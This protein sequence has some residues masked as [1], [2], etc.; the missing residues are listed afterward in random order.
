MKRVFNAYKILFIC[1]VSD[2]FIMWLPKPGYCQGNQ[3][4]KEY[5]TG[6]TVQVVLHLYLELVFEAQFCSIPV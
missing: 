6:R 2:T 5:R 1:S 3:L 4:K